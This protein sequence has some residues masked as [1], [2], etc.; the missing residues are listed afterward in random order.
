M[1]GRCVGMYKAR[2]KTYVMY[3]IAAFGN[4]AECY[5]HCYPQQVWDCERSPFNVNAV[6]LSRKNITIIIPKEDF[7]KHWKVV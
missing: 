1:E 6:K 7:E 5:I 3:R 4:K 2:P